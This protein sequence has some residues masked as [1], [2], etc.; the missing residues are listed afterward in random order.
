MFAS[1]ANTLLGCDAGDFASNGN[2]RVYDLSTGE[3]M[4]TLE[5]GIIPSEVYINE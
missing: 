3:E 2:L 5:V 4:A 1:D